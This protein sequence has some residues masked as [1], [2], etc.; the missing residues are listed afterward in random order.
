[1]NFNNVND[2]LSGY[3]KSQLNDKDLELDGAE[4]SQ[5]NDSEFS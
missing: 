3:T 2:D 5:L 4:M 1:M